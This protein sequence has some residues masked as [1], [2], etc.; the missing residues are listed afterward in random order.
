MEIYYLDEWSSDHNS[1]KEV[2]KLL[3]TSALMVSVLYGEYFTNL[4]YN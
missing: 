4:I 2:W 1:V 3:N